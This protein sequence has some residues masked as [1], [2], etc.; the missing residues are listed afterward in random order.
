MAGQ[1]LLM[2][3]SIY[4]DPSTAIAA[5]AHVEATIRTHGGDIDGAVVLAKDSAGMIL[6]HEVGKLSMAQGPNRGAVLGAV[7]GLLFPPSLIASAFLSAS[8][9]ALVDRITDPKLA[10]PALR[11]LGDRLVAGQAALV[12]VGREAAVN[13]IADAQLGYESLVRRRLSPELVAAVSG[14]T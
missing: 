8:I 4:R 2:T 9:G 3:F 14:Q 6:L 5:A 10:D 13:Q 1:S 12:V 7:V 11:K